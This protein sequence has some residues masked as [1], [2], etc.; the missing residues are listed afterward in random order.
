MKKIVIVKWIKF[1]PR[2]SKIERYLGLLNGFAEAIEDH[3]VC[4]EDDM[5]VMWVRESK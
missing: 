5:K 4:L 3:S 2:G 1:L